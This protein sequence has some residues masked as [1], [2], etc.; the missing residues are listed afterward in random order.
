MPTLKVWY[1]R[2]N[3]LNRWSIYSQWNDGE[4]PRSLVATVRGSEV[5]AMAMTEA[6]RRVESLADNAS[7]MLEAMRRMEVVQ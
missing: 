5:V 6:Y 7:G 2:D 3:T 1:E 4:S